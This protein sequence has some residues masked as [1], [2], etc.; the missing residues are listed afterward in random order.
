MNA[1]NYPPGTGFAA[2]GPPSTR[3]PLLTDRMEAFVGVFAERLATILLVLEFVI[4]GAG[5]LA[6]YAFHAPL[7][8]SDEL[9]SIIFVWLGMIGAVVTHR[10]GEH[11]Q[12]TSYLHQL[13]PVKREWVE[14]GI[15][16][17]TVCFLVV[18]M[19]PIVEALQDEWI[20]RT[21]VLQI[22]NTV[23]V[24]GIAVGFCCMLLLSLLRLNRLSRQKI[25]ISMSAVLLLS[26]LL[27]TLQPVFL[28]LGYY[29]LIIFFLGLGT[30][31]VVIG[32]P[33]AFAF[34]IATFA[35][36]ALA[37]DAPL[38]IIV[39][40]MTEVLSELILLA[41]PMFIALG[42]L[43]VSMGLA[44]ALIEF[45]VALLGHVRGGLS[46]VLVGVIFLVSGISGS[47][48]ADM[49]AVAPI[50][51][52]EMKKRGANHGELIGLLS[53]AGIMSETIP[54]SLVLITI[55]AVTGISIGAL[56][57]AGIYPAVLCSVILVGA[58]YWRSRCDVI[59]TVR[60]SIW[61]IISTFAKSAPALVLPFVIR[62]AVIEGISTATEVATI[63]VAYTTVI[64]AVCYQTVN[65]KSYYP[66]C[67]RTAALSGA[68]LL[69]LAIATAMGWALTQSGF[70][71]R[72]AELM[73]EV[74][75]GKWTFIAISIVAFALLGSVLEGIP[76][77]VLFA[78]LM[79]PS[80]RGLGVDE[81]H[82]A[83]VV[84]L[85]MGLGLFA[86]PFGLGFYTACAIGEVS[87]SKAFRKVWFYLAV[88]AFATMLVGFFPLLLNLR[89]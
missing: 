77:V 18:M 6:R 32:T 17:L 55:G 83:M 3:K 15:S 4:L 43:M 12:F 69:I 11:L 78:P 2:G 70:S 44:N 74:P 25:I 13:T 41:I 60:A 64:G 53:G 31:L 38:G 89:M 73:A 54:P 72:V 27:W 28:T 39:G 46:Y 19:P 45:M 75:G 62:G 26:G 40:R 65:F 61:K 33:I 29:N 10:Y 1:A 22:P 86:P 48:A 66:I 14:A 47:K 82:Y 56:F 9:A 52:P 37:T 30:L 34:G 36:L 71:M 49:A 87:P 59:T 58:I 23:R 24:A 50:L 88:M 63:G 42:L 84:I 80:A 35:Y 76:A 8:W 51:F 85:A 68:V 5:V 16:A 81:I 21:P 79:F 57:A 67:I 20:I 7:V